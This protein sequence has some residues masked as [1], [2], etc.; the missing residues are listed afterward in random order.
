MKYLAAKQPNIFLSR[1]QTKAKAIICN[2]LIFFR[3]P[4]RT[5][6]W[7]QKYRNGLRDLISCAG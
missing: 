1:D 6:K 4:D 2:R 3:R 7:T 5:Q